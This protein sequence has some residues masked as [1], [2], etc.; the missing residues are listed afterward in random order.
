[1]PKPITEWGE[2]ELRAVFGGLPD[3]TIAVVKDD[4]LTVANISRFEM[5]SE[6]V[7][8]DRWGAPIFGSGFFNPV[9]TKMTA[10]TAGD[11]KTNV[12]ILRPSTEAA[13][14]LRLLKYADS[15]KGKEVKA[16]LKRLLARGYRFR[17]A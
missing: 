8:D 5:E 14:D 13:A 4:R 15:Y 17:Y 7:G 3:G 12:V 1:M 16:A 2:D 6:V 9:K 11:G 10:T